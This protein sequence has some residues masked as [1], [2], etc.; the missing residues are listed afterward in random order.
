MAGDLSNSDAAQFDDFHKLA[1]DYQD[2][3]VRCQA[4]LDQ[5]HAAGRQ[6]RELADKLG[7]DVKRDAPP[8]VARALD[9]IVRRSKPS[10]TVER[11]SPREREVF[12]LIG[13]GLATHEISER[14]NVAIS[15]V[16]TYRERLKTKLGLAS[17]HE[18]TR[19]AILSETSLSDGSE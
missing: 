12:E 10:E 18:L 3:I 2:S 15:T 8:D 1:A 6:L 13:L 9:R 5:L 7:R 4:S 16:E 19:Y 17:G 11:L 14:L